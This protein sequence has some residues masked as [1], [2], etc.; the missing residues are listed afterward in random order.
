MTRE[1]VEADVDTIFA[2]YF[3][4]QSTEELYDDDPYNYIPERVSVNVDCQP[5]MSFVRHENQ[6][7]DFPEQL[8]KGMLSEVS[9]MGSGS[10]LPHRAK[11]GGQWFVLK[12]DGWRLNGAKGYAMDNADPHVHNEVVADDFL[13]EAGLNVPDSKEYFADI[14]H[15][16][17]EV[18]RVSRMIEA[19][20]FGLVY[21]QADSTLRT[22]LVRQLI[23]AYPV[24]SLIAAVDTFK[25]YQLDNLMVDASGRVWF[26]D[27]GATFGYR[28]KGQLIASEHFTER[29]DPRGPNGF[30]WLRDH[31]DASHYYCKRDRLAEIFSREGVTDAD[32]EQAASRYHFADLVRTLP[33]E[34][35]TPNLMNYAAACDAL[36]E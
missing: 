31:D 23:V 13:C 32:L 6:I 21:D 24:L 11:I 19:K 7:G 18:I 30:F 15:G 17:K 28:A 4:I 35:Q 14:G 2:F 9:Y 22:R 10:T 33:V 5:R 8:E 16:R 36:G 29:T 20:D 25:H 1:Q 34:Y 26:I 3:V 27:N 12:C